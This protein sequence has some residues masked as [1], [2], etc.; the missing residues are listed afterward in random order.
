MPAM[1]KI[2]ASA[3]QFVFPECVAKGSCF[4]VGVWVHGVQVR[5]AAMGIRGNWRL[6]G[7]CF[8]WQAQGIRSFVDG[9]M[10]AVGISQSAV[11]GRHNGGAP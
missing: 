6:A 8:A 5:T 11:G 10:L 1:H 2:P 3:W 7:R 4:K 9:R